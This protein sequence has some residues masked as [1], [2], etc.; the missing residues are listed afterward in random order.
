MKSR[1][2]SEHAG[3]PIRHKLV[4]FTGL[5]FA[6][7]F[8]LFSSQCRK[9]PFPLDPSTN[10]PTDV[11]QI[12]VGKCAISGCHNAL[13]KEACGG[14]DYS[15]WDKLF[16]GGHNNSSVIPYRP[17]QSYLFF[18]VNTFSDLGPHLHPTMPL[19]HPHLTRDEVLQVRDWIANGAPGANGDVKFSGNPNRRKIYV[20][21]QGCD[22]VTVI[23][24]ETKL[25]MRCVDVGRNSSTESPHD[26]TVSPDGQFWYVTFYIGNYLQKYSC[27]DDRLVAE[28]DLGTSSWHS[29]AISP[30]SRYALVSHWEAT[31]RVGLIDL[32]N[33]TI[34]KMYLGLYSYPHGCAFSADGHYS[35]IVSQM[36]NFL[37]KTDLTDLI[38]VNYDMIPLQ[39]GDIPQNSGPH[40]PYVVKFSPDNSK[41]YVICQGTDEVR[42]YN[43]AN[44]SLI[45]IIPTT[46]VP[47]LIEF[48]ETTPY[49]FV[50][51][52]SDTN[53]N[54]VIS[55][56]DILN[57]NNDTYVRTV[58]PGFE[59]RGLAVDDVNGVVYVGNRNVDAGG[60]APHHTT[61]CVGKNGDVTIISLSTLQV[62]PGWRAEVSVDPYSLTI[63]H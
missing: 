32:E 36:G 56:V 31:G 24:A 43:P 45:Q 10:Y 3:K 62:V 4:L 37:Y 52:M 2:D 18:S 34:L 49:A 33:M 12:L 53:N 16:E 27:V 60:P 8:L 57:Y 48:S 25:V 46:G 63:R 9:D 13:S 26:I 20:A 42:V 61:A 23:D 59:E 58:Y 11:G 7:I 28:L 1:T 40:K 35:Y 50:T 47:Q 15:T 44:D 30:D 51:C 14:L 39:T 17:D 38:S 29:M 22:L 5:F 19:N 55:S 41:Y 21:N 6:F 54:N